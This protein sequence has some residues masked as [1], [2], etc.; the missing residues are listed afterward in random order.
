M[1]VCQ[2]NFFGKL[3]V[4]W[5]SYNWRC[6]IPCKENYALERGFL[7]N[8]WAILWGRKTYII[9]YVVYFKVMR[10]R[11][12]FGTESLDWNMTFSPNLIR[13]PSKHIIAGHIQS[14]M[15]SSYMWLS[16][17]FCDRCKKLMAPGTRRSCNT[18]ISNKLMTATRMKMWICYEFYTT[19][20]E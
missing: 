12:I 10:P 7:L 6:Q 4:H 14:I 9:G 1:A 19:D 16:N 3:A 20:K 2:P 18:K 17:P 15:W 8:L 5:T 13:F 11:R